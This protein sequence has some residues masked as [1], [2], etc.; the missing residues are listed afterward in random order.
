[1]NNLFE[2]SQEHIHIVNFCNI[3]N[4]EEKIIEYEKINNGTVME[5]VEIAKRFQKN[6][7]CWRKLWIENFGKSLEYSLMGPS[8]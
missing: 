7:K 3:L 5:K 6:L 8:D 1:M 2:E 4:K